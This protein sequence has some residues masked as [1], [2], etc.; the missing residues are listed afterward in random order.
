MFMWIWSMKLVVEIYIEDIIRSFQLLIGN[1]ERYLLYRF[2]NICLNGFRIFR[3]E[4][5]P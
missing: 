3:I 2:K 5:G 1:D 4:F